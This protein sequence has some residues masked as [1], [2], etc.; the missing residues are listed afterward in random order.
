MSSPRKKSTQAFANKREPTGFWGLL[1]IVIALLLTLFQLY[2]AFFGIFVSLLQRSLHLGLAL[3]LVFLTFSHSA[4]NKKVSLFDILLLILTTVSFGYVVCNYF[5][6]ANRYI[7]VE[8]LT[9]SEVVLGCIGVLLVIEACRRVVGNA[10]ASLALISVLYAFGGHYLPGIFYHPHISPVWIIEQLFYTTEGIFAIPIGVSATYASAFIIFG[11]FLQKSGAGQF[12]IDLSLATMGKYRGGP[13]KTAILASGFLGMLNGSSTANVLTT[14]AFTIPMMKKIGYKPYFAGAVE[15]SASTGGMLMPPIMGATA[16]ILAEFTGIPYREVAIAAII[17]A[18]LYYFSIG[19]QVHLRAVKTGLTGLPKEQVPKVSNVLKSGLQF[20]IPLVVITYMLLSGY[21]PLRS[22][23][24]G[25]ITTILTSYF[26]PETRMSLHDIYAGLILSAKNILVIAISC[27]AAG[28]IIGVATQTGL[29]LQL[30]R[31]IVDASQDILLLGLILTMVT[32]IILGMGLPTSAAYIIQAALIVP[33]LITLGIST[34]SANLFV[35]YFACLSFVTPPVALAAFAGAGVA[36]AEAMRTGFAAWKLCLAAFIVPFM[37]VYGP[38]I[39]MQGTVLEIITTF[40]TAMLGITSLA[41]SIEGWLCK[42][43]GKLERVL[44]FVS[45]L[46]L[47]K[48]GLLTDTMGLLL[49]A[50]VVILQKMSI[51]GGQKAMGK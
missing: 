19:L 40:A 3:L 20:F 13:A 34:L 7:F 15:A 42:E 25:I 30:S 4:Q 11:S 50:G 48:P 22:A 43:T 41:C 32:S 49:F 45:A 35:F 1:V 21:S 24:W 10:L 18:I 28:I 26:N 23:L 46:T 5:R 14:G 9:T 38:S 16:F 29:G 51:S 33:A 47:I 44:L 37:F 36:G 27:G 31:L 39:L 12:F 2:T 6:L 8:E 17:P